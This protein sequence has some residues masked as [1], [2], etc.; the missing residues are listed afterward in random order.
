MLTDAQLYH[1]AVHGWV[2]QENIFSSEEIDT[3][4]NALDR[5]YE[6]KVSTMVH[7]DT[8]D[9]KNIDN[10]VNYDQI[11]RDWIMNPKI[12]PVLKQLLG[13]PPRFECCH[14]M[15]KR[16]HP[17][18]ETK[19]SQLSDPSE[20]GWHRGI[21][22]KYGIVAANNHTYINTTFLNNATYL[23]D[24]GPEDGGTMILD[25]SHQIEAQYWREVFDPSMI[26]QIKAKAGS[27]LHFTEALIHTGVPIL[28]ERTRYTMFYGFTPPW[29]Q[30]WPGCNPTQEIINSSQGELKEI[31]GART[32][33]MGQY[34]PE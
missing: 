26:V 15:I 8:T 9:I 7:Q 33:Y 18:R 21:R 12:L 10:M 23:T 24:V 30:C 29:M 13:T 34:Q 2:L 3:F 31:L 20:M 28:S 32:G 25:G 17:D 16:P 4:R 5:L 14:A 6:S 22:P 19:W 27:V 1:F 11:F